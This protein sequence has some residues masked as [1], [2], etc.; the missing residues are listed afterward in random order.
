MITLCLLQGD[1]AD[2]PQST[3][4]STLN[5][6]SAL[7]DNGVLIGRVVLKGFCVVLLV[8]QVSMKYGGLLR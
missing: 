3:N 2:A 6:A 4:C 1:T 5:T 8:A 7:T